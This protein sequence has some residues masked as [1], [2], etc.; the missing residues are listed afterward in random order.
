M[1]CELLDIA[2]L[3]HKPAFT[4][5]TFICRRIGRACIK[6]RVTHLIKKGSTSVTCS[7]L[8]CNRRIQMPT[9]RVGPLGLIFWKQT[10]E[11][12]RK[13]RPQK[14]GSGSLPEGSGPSGFRV[15]VRLQRYRGSGPCPALLPRAESLGPSKLT[16]RFP[17][18]WMFQ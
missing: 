1:N 8:A 6:Y 7:K 18:I 3:D 9:N 16:S 14:K 11:R 10:W 13:F 4:M 17:H 2:I 5:C 15:P 12:F